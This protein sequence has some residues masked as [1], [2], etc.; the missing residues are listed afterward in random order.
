MYVSGTIYKYEG[1]FPAAK[2]N[3]CQIQNY[4]PEEFYY[5]NFFRYIAKLSNPKLGMKLGIKMYQT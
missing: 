2:N 1:F 4:V 5:T 3:Y